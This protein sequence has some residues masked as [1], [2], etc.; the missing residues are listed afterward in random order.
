MERTDKDNIKIDFQYKFRI[1][2]KIGYE[3]FYLPWVKLVDFG[4]HNFI[5]ESPEGKKEI[6]DYEK[7]WI[8]Y[9]KKKR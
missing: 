9:E 1:N 6:Y 7:P 5:G 8:S 2:D 4:H 3:G